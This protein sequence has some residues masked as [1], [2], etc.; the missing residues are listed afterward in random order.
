MKDLSWTNGKIKLVTHFYLFST[1][2]EYLSQ[3][4]LY[5]HLYCNR[6]YY[7]SSSEACLEPRQISVIE[8][9][10]ENS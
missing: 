5:F 1:L 7:H 8:I 9:C 2:L 10:Y 3:G 6:K 4:V